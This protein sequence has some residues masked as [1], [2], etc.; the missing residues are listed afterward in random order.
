[1]RRIHL[2]C[3][4]LLSV[5][6][7]GVLSPSAF[8]LTFVLGEWLKNGAA[9]TKAES[10]VVEGEFRFENV[11]NL[12]AI[13]CSILLEGSVSPDGEGEMTKAFTL[14]G[15]EVK[16]LDATGATS[17]LACIGIEGHTCEAGS[18]A[19]PVHLP[20]K[21]LLDLDATEAEWFLRPMTNGAGLLPAFFILCKVFGADVEELCEMA[22]TSF[23]E[24]VDATTDVESISAI[25]P[26][27]TCGANAEEGRI[28][29]NSENVALI[30]LLAGTLS[31][32]N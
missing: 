15:G 29:N 27:S 28:E 21:S 13:L 2:L 8:A 14:T 18:S 1:M 11:L 9:I 3:I 5:C 26:P 6:V 10:A 25:T 20:F 24:V 19:W 7:V 30:A 22:A 17:G 31:V 4:A 12:A 23:G 32:S 16:E